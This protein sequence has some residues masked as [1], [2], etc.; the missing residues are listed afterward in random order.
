[1]MIDRRRASASVSP[2]SKPATIVGLGTAVP[3]FE[4]DQREIAEFAREMFAHRY[5]DFERMVAV[6][7]SAGICKRHIVKPREW[8][9]REQHWPDRT[10]AYLEGAEALYI[11]AAN[12]ALENAGC[13]ADEVDT[14]VTISS[15]GVAT[16]SL[17]ARVAE[18]MGFRS[19]AS[20]VPVFGLGCAGG[21]AGLSI[22][23]RLAEARPGTT[24]LMVAVEICSVAFRLDELNKAN[25][26]ATA[27]F[28]DGAA[29]AVLRVAETGICHIEGAG[30]HTWPNTLNIMG[31]DVDPEGLGV[32]FD[33]EIPP[34]AEQHFGPAIEDILARMGLTKSD[35]GRFCCHPGGAK[36]VQALEHTLSLERRSLDHERQ[37]LADFGNMSAPTV[38]FVLE[39]LVKAGLPKRTAMTALGPGFSTH[40]LSLLR[41]A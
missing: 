6:F 20:R 38:L 18:T 9:T 39:R 36:V 14:I 3:P 25:I 33:R 31:W 15:T 13:K 11:D 23:A 12:K 16:P 37:V 26:V 30:E 28:A 24:V 7:Y 35:I 19:D 8:Y 29:A 5:P 21:T 22:A 34:F 17:E 27:L 2:Q 1:M 32:I 4:L 10:E 40:C 41:A